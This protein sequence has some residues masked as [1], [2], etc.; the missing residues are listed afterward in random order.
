MINGDKV[1]TYFSTIMEKTDRLDVHESQK[2]A[3]F[4]RGFPK[5][6]KTYIKQEKPE[7]LL[8]TLKNAKEAEEIGSN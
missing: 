7:G 4:D 1:Q 6:V 2:I 8:E 3:I 5:Y